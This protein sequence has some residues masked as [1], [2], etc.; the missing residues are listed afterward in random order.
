[1]NLA[2]LGAPLLERALNAY[3]SLDGETAARLA[4]IS[5]KLIA[6]K[7]VG[8]DVSLLVR[9]LASRV[10]VSAH[11]VFEPDTVISAGSAARKSSRCRLRISNT[12]SAAGDGRSTQTKVSYSKAIGGQLTPGRSN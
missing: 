6:I 11:P 4:T 8:P 12:R 9:P 10:Q 7:L 1:M 3:L 2:K 5:G